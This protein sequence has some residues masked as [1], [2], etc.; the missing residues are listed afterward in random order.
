MYLYQSIIFK[1]IKIKNFALLNTKIKRIKIN[2]L[3]GKSYKLYDKIEKR[4]VSDPKEDF[5]NLLRN[6]A[7]NKIV[8]N[9]LRW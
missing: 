8:F 3:D 6:I 1:E 2:T 4:A 9:L 5:V 7:T